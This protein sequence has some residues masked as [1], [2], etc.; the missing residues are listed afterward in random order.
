[1][2]LNEFKKSLHQPSPPAGLKPLLLS[3]W[4]E[5]KGDW[6][7]SHNI[8]QAIVSSDGFRVHAYLHRKEGDE[9]NAM[10]WYHR[11]GRTTPEVSL[12]Q[13]WDDLVLMFLK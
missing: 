12:E 9:S 6:E 7:K 1:M 13:E 4:H 3:L 11:A 10:Y 5:G 8:A 2:T